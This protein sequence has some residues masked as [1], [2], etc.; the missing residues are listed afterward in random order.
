VFAKKKNT[1]SELK[2]E[3]KKRGLSTDGLKA[4]LATRLQ[5][6]LDEEEFGLAEAP[7]DG[8]VG[9]TPSKESTAAAASPAPSPAAAAANTT[10]APMAAAPNASAAPPAEAKS[11]AAGSPKP[12]PA[13]P[14]PTNKVIDTSGMTFEEKKKARQ[15]RFGLLT[16]GEK[17][18]ARAERFGVS[19]DKKKKDNKRGRGDGKAGKGGDSKRSKGND[20]GKGGKR[21]PKKPNFDSL[22]KEELEARLKRASKYDLANENVDAMK[23]ALR[24]FRFEEKSE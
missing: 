12:A 10:E 20:G 11:A 4:E 7:K 22:S 19:E 16:E 9:T 2:E 14:A 15:A 24:K 13:A 17:K 8:A 3:L 23:A 6:R 21:E 1:V 18:K 5:V